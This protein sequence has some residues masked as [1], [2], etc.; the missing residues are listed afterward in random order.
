LA[1]TE[2]R[3]PVE[4]RDPLAAALTLDTEAKRDEIVAA[5]RAKERCT[6]EAGVT[7]CL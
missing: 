2:L 3:R 4:T 1:D 5:H 7:S 6:G